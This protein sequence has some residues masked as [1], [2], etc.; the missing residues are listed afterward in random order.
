MP[1]SLTADV[2][3]GTPDTPSSA[4]H[5]LHAYNDHASF[6]YASPTRTLLGQGALDQRAVPTPELTA[7][8]TDLL[9]PRPGQTRPLL[10]GAV[11]FHAEQPAL[12]LRAQRTQQAGRLP[13]LPHPGTPAPRT[14]RLQPTPTPDAYE[15]QVQAARRA[16]QDGTLRKVVLAR[17]LHVTLDDV[18]D[19]AAVLRHLAQR[20]PDGYTFA[21]RTGPDTHLLGASPELLLTRHGQQVHLHPMA[22]T[23][24]RAH[25]PAED[26][27]RAHALARSAKDLHEHALV[28]DAIRSALTPLCAELHVPEQPRVVPTA[29]LWH[30]ATRI[31]GTLRDPRTSALDLVRRLHPTPAV[32]G[33]PHDAAR[34]FIRRTEPFERDLFT[35]AVGWMDADGDG[36]WAVTIRCADVRGREARLYAGAGIVGASD[37]AAER[38]ETAA[39]F[40]TMLHAL[41]VHADGE[42]L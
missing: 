8:A 37:P 19:R 2:P 4:T 34:A 27:E 18:I 16:C 26:A 5:L 38:R 3:A 40:R 31:T 22:G 30:L 35:G 1:V 28:V 32:C 11:P 36:E 9:R 17:T 23:C 21:L 13:A 14:A 33:V 10:V 20:N 39:K 15:A 25:D 29:T 6:F 7:H 24:A 42:A 41:G 12:L